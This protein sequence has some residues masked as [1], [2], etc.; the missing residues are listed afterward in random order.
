MKVPGAVE[1]LNQIVG[2]SVTYRVDE[3]DI[4]AYYARP[5]EPGR[6]PG[7]IVIHEAFGP[8]EHINDVARPEFV[9][10]GRYTRSIER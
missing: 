5:K 8:V 4:E 10:P 1:D 3:A 6:Y 2:E 9:F 7:I